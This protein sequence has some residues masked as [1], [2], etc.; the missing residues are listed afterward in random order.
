MT[1]RFLNE[2]LRGPVAWIEYN[3]PPRNAIKWLW[4]RIWDEGARPPYSSSQMRDT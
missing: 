3:N 1:Y 4:Q 2:Q